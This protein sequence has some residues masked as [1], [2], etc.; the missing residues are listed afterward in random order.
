MKTRFTQSDA[1]PARTSLLVAL[2]ACALSA[3][4]LCPKD[5]SAQQPRAP[6]PA[7]DATGLMNAGGSVY[8]RQA[9]M[10]D[11]GPQ[12]ELA[13]HEDDRG[14]R[15]A[16]LPQ[17]GT[18]VAQFTDREPFILP[19]GD[20]NPV[21]RPVR[22]PATLSSNPGSRDFFT[23]EPDE[24]IS[25]IS[26]Y[27]RG[28]FQKLQGSYAYIPS[29][30]ENQPDEI[31]LQEAN[32]NATFAL[33]APSAESPLLITPSFDT[34]FLDGPDSPDLPARLYGASVQAMWVPRINDRLQ[35]ILAF[36]PGAYGD[37]ESSDQDM[38]R[39]E[40]QALFK[41]EPFRDRLQVVG[42]VLYLD[43]E[44][45]DFLPAGGVIW[46]PT[47]N[48]Q[49]DLLF[50]IPKAAMRVYATPE[51]EWWVFVA[52][53]FS[54]ETFAFEHSDQVYD[55][56]AIKDMRAFAGVEMK[57]DGGSGLRL[58]AGYV[59]DRS[60]EFRSLS[61]DLELEDTYMLRAVVAY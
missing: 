37:F 58:E 54:N 27:K 11:G 32:I 39:Y 60:I 7:I 30:D 55:Q 23:A 26:P 25:G 57:R 56:L 42:G 50:P 44:D 4:A 51:S 41:W 21:D 1:T 45:L 59:F 49:F 46:T 36:Q 18:R 6:M 22:V 29:A 13:R 12:D 31:N 5:L 61:P 9:S 38:W 3:A 35:L 53:E 43:R 19:P 47:D 33:P 10:L 52:G 17:E 20:G 24:L 28:F 15:T 40:A 48:Y 14:V 8:A 16:A 2:G 34:Y